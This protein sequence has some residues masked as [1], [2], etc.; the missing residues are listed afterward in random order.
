M[1]NIFS[2]KKVY[3][4]HHF[5]RENIISIIISR[6][7]FVPKTQINTW[8]CISISYIPTK[9][10]IAP[11]H[12]W[13]IIEVS[14][15]LQPWISTHGWRNNDFLILKWRLAFI[16]NKS[17]LRLMKLE[18]VWNLRRN[19]AKI[20]YHCLEWKRDNR[21]IKIVKCSYDQ[22][23]SIARVTVT[24]DKARS[25]F[26]G[27]LQSALKWGNY[28]SRWRQHDRKW[29]RNSWTTS[30]LTGRFVK[31]PPTIYVHYLVMPQSWSVYTCANFDSVPDTANRYMFPIIHRFG[32]LYQIDV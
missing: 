26:I 14:N 8:F 28:H 24:S 30:H 4:I 32:T 5:E 21:T 11:Q 31:G 16:E 18:N 17:Y 15:C 12:F 29:Y 23:I 2:F 6:L 20:I 1:Q 25:H 27:L 9:E 13:G 10:D 7:V 19:G 22:C 3:N